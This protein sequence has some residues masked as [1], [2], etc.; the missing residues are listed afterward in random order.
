VEIIDHHNLGDIGT[1][2]PINFR[3]KPVGC[4]ATII[5]ES[6]VENKVAIPKYIAGLLVSAILSDTLLLTSPTTTDEDKKAASKL[7]KTANI[8]LEKYGHMMIKAASSIKGMTINEQ[9]Y[10]DYKSY[11]V[12]NRQLGI[13]QL[14]TLDIDLIKDNLDAYVEK[15]DELHFH[16]EG[17]YALFVSDPIKKG[18]YV[19]YNE[20]SSG[21]IKEAFNLDE[22]YQGVF[23]KGII[24][25]KKQ[26]IPAIMNILL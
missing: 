12:G 8:N 24:S 11:T 5:Y 4:T 19:F 9:I 25:R 16:N 14:M 17:L 2:I 10:Q 21:I 6:F 22:V 3:S 20:L 15:L 1:T 13:G 18:S 26:I 23:I 7:A